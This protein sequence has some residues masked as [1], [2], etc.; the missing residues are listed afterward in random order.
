[1]SRGWGGLRSSSGKPFCSGSSCAPHRAEQRAGP[2][3]GGA[4]GELNP[5]RGAD[6]AA[7]PTGSPTG[8]H[9]WPGAG[10]EGPQPSARSAL[11]QRSPACSCTFT[12][13]EAHAYSQAHTAL[14]SRGTSRP[15]QPL[16]G[17]TPSLRYRPCCLTPSPTT[18]MAEG[19]CTGNGNWGHPALQGLPCRLLGGLWTLFSGH[20]CHM[21]RTDVASFGLF[22]L[23]KA[24][25]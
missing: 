4:G 5:P 21:D 25:P 17:R 19:L 14:P 23:V 24:I 18:P 6:A 7:H 3:H 9:V 10:H 22:S 12:C 15:H 20:P 8:C 13:S 11:R 16:V 2:H 1:M